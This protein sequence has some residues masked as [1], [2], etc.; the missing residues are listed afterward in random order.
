MNIYDIC[1]YEAAAAMEYPEGTEPAESYYL[2]DGLYSNLG[3]NRT[4]FHYNTEGLKY[5]KL[6]AQSLTEALSIFTKAHPSFI[7][8]GI[9][10]ERTHHSVVAV[11]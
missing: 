10:D 7:V 2:P 1:Y 11:G 4:I 5:E 6:P 8:V 9:E 3:R